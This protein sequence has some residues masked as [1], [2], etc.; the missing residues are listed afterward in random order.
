MY[1]PDWRDIVHLAVGFTVGMFWFQ[2]TA[3]GSGLL[4]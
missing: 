1:R 4:Q 3:W 2:I